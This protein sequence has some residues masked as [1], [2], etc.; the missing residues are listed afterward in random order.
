MGRGKLKY[1]LA[2]FKINVDAFPYAYNVY[3]SYGEALLAYGDRQAAIDNY[4]KSVS[5]N[6]EN[7]NGIEVLQNLGEPTND[8][9]FKVPAEHLKLMEGEYLATHD[10][11][12][13][14]VVEVN[15]GVLK[16]VDKYYKFTLVPIGDNQFVNPRF[17][18]LWRVEINDSGGKPVLHFGKYRFPKVE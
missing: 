16:C 4:K 11:D 8:L 1:A 18:A 14:I 15:D 5:L 2:I 17:G 9:V 12:W 6:P 7:D 3:D 13:R 10:E